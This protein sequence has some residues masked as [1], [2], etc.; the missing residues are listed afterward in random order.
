MKIEF[1]KGRLQYQSGPT[2]YLTEGYSVTYW[3]LLNS[4]ILHWS[5]STHA[6]LC[7]C[8]GYLLSLLSSV[9][10]TVTQLLLVVIVSNC[11]L[12]LSTQ[13]QLLKIKQAFYSLLLSRLQ[14][15][16]IA[17]TQLHAVSN[18]SI[19]QSALAVWVMQA[20]FPQK[21]GCYFILL[22]VKN[23]QT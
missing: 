5:N 9:G 21:Y 10:S 22:K 18:E 7:C 14:Q 2:W 8:P 3:L 23:V 1:R 13:L 19:N 20:V 16:N 6:Q 11:F 12:K 15:T 17:I 4:I